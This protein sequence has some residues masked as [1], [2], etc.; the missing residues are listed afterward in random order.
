MKQF[1]VTY[2]L[3]LASSQLLAADVWNQK[4]SMPAEGRHR[5]TGF[6]IGNKGYMGLGHY[7]SG[8]NGNI[9]KADIWEYDP[10]N[11][12]WTQKAD[13]GGG[14]TY[15]AT[16][17]TIDQYAYVGAHVYGTSEFYK[18]DPI[19]NEW[20]P[21]SSSPE[22]AADHVSFSLNGKGYFMTFSNYY[23]YKPINDQWALMGSTPSNVGSWSNAF[24]VGEKGYLLAT[25]GSLYEYKE[26][27]NTWT[28]RSDFPGE[29]VG[30]WSNFVANGKAYIFSGYIAFLNPTSRQL[31]EYDPAT[32]GWNQMEDLPGA[33]RRFSSAFS[34]G[35]KGYIGT[36]TNGTNMSDLWEF[37]QVLASEKLTLDEPQ[38]IFDNQNKTIKFILNHENSIAGLDIYNLSGQLILHLDSPTQNEWISLFDFNKGLYICVL[39]DVNNHVYSKKITL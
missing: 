34:I 39:R 29:S 15:G 31:W 20:T 19:A 17:F 4:S 25:N 14:P 6:S 21:I 27:T 32:N 24:A 10:T 7:N 2:L 23:Q 30:G 18:F 28:Y 33:T 1:L 35:N 16:A 9:A 11:D 12:S 3:L 38:I 22:G 8:P 36:G 37:D 13:Y 5:T 26:I